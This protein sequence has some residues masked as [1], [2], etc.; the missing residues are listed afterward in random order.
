[1]CVYTAQ[2]ILYIVQTT[3]TL[4]KPLDNKQH[5]QKT[6]PHT[7]HFTSSGVLCLRAAH[8]IVQVP[9]VGVC[10][11]GWVVVGGCESKRERE[12]VSDSVW[13]A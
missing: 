5:T 10:G 4:Y 6:T 2:Q 7:F 3:Q 8:L 13:C 9:T 1:M 11:G 12:E